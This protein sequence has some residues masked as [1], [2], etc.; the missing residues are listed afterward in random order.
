[1]CVRVCPY[2]IASVFLCVLSPPTHTANYFCKHTTLLP[3]PA[4]G[5]LLQ[6]LCGILLGDLL[7]VRIHL[8][9]LGQSRAN[10][11]DL[12]GGARE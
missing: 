3:S 2:T 6:H 7:K 4:Y 12:L 9:H 1:M 11:G 10:E 8:G 5:P